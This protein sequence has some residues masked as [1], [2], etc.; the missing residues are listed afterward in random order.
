MNEE[1]PQKLLPSGD[2]LVVLERRSE[3]GDDRALIAVNRDRRRPHEIMPEAFFNESDARL[4]P[5]G[6]M[7]EPLGVRVLHAG[8]AVAERGPAAAEAEVAMP[9]LWRPEAR[10]AIENVYPE[11]D[12]GRYPVKRIEGDTFEVWADLFRDGHDALRSIVKYRHE[13]A[14]WRE[15]P[16]IFFDN[17]RWVARFPL[18]RV[19]LWQYTIEAWTDRFA[20]WREEIEKKLEAGQDIAL[21]LDE[22]RAILE[23]ALIE[24]RLG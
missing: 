6:L 1:G 2:D 8:P 4:P 22:G 5:N 16:L 12:G 13:T 19:G 24:A 7:V 14:A 21:E 17:D 20:S 9:P 15:A 18:D 10:I 11:L 23:E 3:S